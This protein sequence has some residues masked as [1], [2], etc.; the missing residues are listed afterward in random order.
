MSAPSPPLTASA[1]SIWP[2]AWAFRSRASEHGQTTLGIGEWPKGEAHNGVADG[3]YRTNVF[4]IV[5]MSGA[6]K[7]QWQGLLRAP[8]GRRFQNRHANARKMRAETP[9]WWRALRMVFALVIVAVGMVF[10]FI[11]GPAILFFAI[12]GALLATESR[13]IACGL[14]WTELRLRAVWIWGRRHW[15]TLGLVGR[16]AV[17]VLALVGSLGATIAAWYVFLG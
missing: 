2:T 3:H 10:V 8:P 11:P 14:D 15:R 16:T 1:S 5:S 13:P 4:S 6:F 12:A 7:R 17:T 9:L